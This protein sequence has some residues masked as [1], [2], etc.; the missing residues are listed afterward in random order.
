MQNVPD[1]TVISPDKL[2]KGK[3]YV[4][5]VQ[6]W[7]NWFYQSNPDRNNNGDVVF[8]QSPPFTE[9]NGRK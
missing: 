6:D 7:S 3:R 4:E 8:L 9:R 1:Y 2:F 5:W